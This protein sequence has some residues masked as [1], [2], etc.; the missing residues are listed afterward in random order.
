M[1]LPKLVLIALNA[2]VLMTPPALAQ[3]PSPW[4]TGSPPSTRPMSYRE[5]MVRM[6]E[7]QAF[8]ART[9][10]SMQAQLTL[11]ERTNDPATRHAA[12]ESIRSMLDAMQARMAQCQQ[13]AQMM[14]R[15]MPSG[16][17]NHQGMGGMMGNPPASGR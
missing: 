16:M 11:A 7:N 10:K 4:M 2:I 3:T 14:N 9:M 13:M 8:M 12:L 15:S 6:Q 1:R 5:M 17:M